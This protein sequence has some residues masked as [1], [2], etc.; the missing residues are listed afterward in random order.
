MP[1]AAVTDL[2]GDEV[3]HQ[4]FYAAQ[5][6]SLALVIYSEDDGQKK[7]EKNS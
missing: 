5:S 7:N 3:L 6:G 1:C 4:A 2:H